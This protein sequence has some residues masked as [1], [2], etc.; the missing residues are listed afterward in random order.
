MTAAVQGWE[1]HRVAWS[2][3]VFAVEPESFGAQSLCCNDERSAL[4][5]S[6]HK[7]PGLLHGSCSTA[8]VCR[9]SASAC[10]HANFTAAEKMHV[11]KFVIA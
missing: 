3:D 10:S 7:V 2:L 1:E 6:A 11:P 8:A 5:R 4:D 9:R